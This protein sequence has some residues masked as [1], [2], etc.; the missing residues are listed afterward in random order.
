MHIPWCIKK[1]PYCDFNSHASQARDVN[2]NE[3]A[4]VDRLIDDITMHLPMLATRLINTIFIGGGTPSLLSANAYARLFDFIRQHCHVSD[5]VEITLEA[6]P[7][8]VEQQRFCDYRAIGINRLSLGVQSFSDEALIELG[9]IHDGAGANAAIISA[10]RAGFERINIDIMYGLTGQTTQAALAD[11]QRALHY[12]VEHISWYQLTIEPNTVFYRYPPALP[13]VDHIV[14]IEDAGQQLLAEAGFTRYEISAYCCQSAYCQHNL[15]YWRYGDY[16]GIGAGAHS[17]ITD[18]ITNVI[19]RFCKAKQPT[20]YLNAQ[21][22]MLTKQ[23]Q[24]SSDELPFEFMLNVL[25]LFK[26]TTFTHFQQCTGLANTTI[27]ATLNVAKQRGWLDYDDQQFWPTVSGYR[28]LNDLVGL[29]L[30]NE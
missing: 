23:Q 18:P 13:D 14:A 5:T 9:R 27:M 12:D 26:P 2:T 25:R 3:E 24:V 16:L 17:K 11:L 30:P 7:G 1:C 22:N 4:Y 20:H 19:T 28:Y 10:Q 21:K 15:N 29:F 8:T 6:N